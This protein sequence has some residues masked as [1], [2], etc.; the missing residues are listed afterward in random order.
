MGGPIRVFMEGS[1]QVS[2][3]TAAQTAQSDTAAIVLAANAKR[4][5]VIIQ[6][7]GTTIIKLTFGAVVPTQTAYHV[8]LAACTGADDGK[9]G[10]YVDDSWVGVINAISSA[11]GGTLVITEFRTGSPDW[12]RAADWGS[13]S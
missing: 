7:T 11:A 3:S 6:N 2:V 1:P 10:I 5:G 4:K 8:A 9:G 13:P 12:N